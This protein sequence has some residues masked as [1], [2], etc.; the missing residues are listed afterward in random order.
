MVGRLKSCS[1]LFLCALALASFA[2]AKEPV[3][4]IENQTLQI[5]WSQS[6]NR[7]TIFYKPSRRA[8]LNGIRLGGE[9]GVGGVVPVEDK[10]F[11][12]GKALKIEY[13]DGS[14][15]KI[16]LFPGLPFALF[17]ATLQCPATGQANAAAEKP[18]FTA[19]V[20][21]EKMAGGAVRSCTA[22]EL[23][24]L[25]TAGLRAPGENPGSYVWLAVAEPESRAGAVF[26]WLT[27]ER[28][29]GIV[30]SGVTNDAVWVG[31]RIDYGHPGFKAGEA[32]DL[33]TFA[34]GYFDDARLGLEA[35]ADALAKAAN[36]RLPPQPAVYCTW[37]SQP[38]GG[39]SDELHLAEQAEFAAAHLAPFG[40][41]VIQ[42]DDHWQSGI[43]RDGP[44]RNFS[45]ANPSGPYPGGMKATADHIHSLGLTP[46]LWFM[47]FA[48][49]PYDPYY[50][51]HPDW[52]VK[53]TNG[54]PYH[55][56]WG[57]DSLDM[58]YEGARAHLRELVSQMASNWGYKYFKID[59][60]WTGTATK[61]T[62]VSTGYVK[63][64]LGQAVFHD[65]SKSPI[66]AFRDGLRL[67]RQAA[68]PGVFILGCN[69]PQNMR[70]YGAAMGLV[71][72]MRIGPDNGTSWKDLLRGPTFGSRH[73]FLNGRV[74]YNDPDP[75]YVRPSVPLNQAR[76]ICSWVTISGQLNTSSEWYPGL[77]SD[78]L[79]LLKRTMPSHGLPARPVDIFE[80]AI[81]RVWLLNDTRQFP[82]RSVI[83]LFNW[84][85][86]EQQFDCDL[87]RMGLDG[88][89]EYA[90][91]DYWRDTLLAP[92]KG[93][94]RMS[95]PGR[96]CCVL[97]VRPVQPHP[98]VIST[99]RHITQGIMDVLEER[100]NP[101]TRTLEGRGKV[102]AGDPYEI[103]I[104]SDKPMKV[105]ASGVSSADE[106]VGVGIVI[107][108]ESNERL[109]RAKI[110]APV[111]R[112]VSWAVKFR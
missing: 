38:H 32:V 51:N 5:N 26:G 79:D 7:A 92:M 13:P 74:W 68:G 60:L 42:I 39:A 43:S 78:R 15:D 80:N 67:V 77:P 90:A 84:E 83:G 2:S 81:P 31:A 14:C 71:D 111:S 87:G 69:G 102:V 61:L 98:Q 28:G 53:Q 93:R 101:R 18:R 37:Y 54:E 52:F 35:W 75:L 70:S 58:T 110:A 30:L 86:E 66:E 21:V 100:W 95:V 85:N 25:G 47:P 17:R 96:S 3:P 107:A 20:D 65:R 73:Y 12:A 48:G 103:R 108:P 91:F 56:R 55:A 33:E 97:A 27:G 94:L 106:A 72:G 82:A 1:V 41:S 62:Y 23:K 49:T 76:L 16:M 24:T 8:F 45:A 112:E 34:A 11:G 19:R 63:D 46:G 105:S 104:V 6:S 29:S 57:G 50:E 36:I 40:L 89:G 109:I 99:S 59:G 4:S 22:A 10:T 88:S 44:R 64:D 9:R